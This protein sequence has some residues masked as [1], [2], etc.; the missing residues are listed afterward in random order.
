VVWWCFWV[1]DLLWLSLLQS[2]PS[3]VLPF[4]SKNSEAESHNAE[5]LG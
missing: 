2:S 5:Q 3:L 4:S 1:V